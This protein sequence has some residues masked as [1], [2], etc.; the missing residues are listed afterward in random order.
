MANTSESKFEFQRKT[1]IIL[2][3]DVTDEKSALEVTSQVAGL[4]DAVKIG[5]PL[6]LGT[7]LPIVSKLA[8]FAP[9]IADFKVA[10]IPNTD[11]LI[12]E[13]VFKAGCAAIIVQ[14][15]T[16]PDSLTECV[17]TADEFGGKVFVVSEMS[18]P[19]GDY[20]FTDSVSK[21]IAALAKKSNAFGIVAPATRPERVK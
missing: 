2:A 17:K 15:F 4:V 10:D 3:L 6:I 16:G 7:G 13:H 5:Y 8:E 21:E 9:V 11:R 19:G 20:F 18:H 14:G 12:C 1:G